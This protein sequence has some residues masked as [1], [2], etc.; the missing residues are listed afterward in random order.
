MPDLV[1]LDVL[2]EPGSEVG[3]GQRATL[4]VTPHGTV[5]VEVPAAITAEAVRAVR[6]LGPVRA[7]IPSHPHMFGLQSVW[8]EALGD[9]DV[10]VARADEHWLG[11]RPRRLRIWSG[12]RE[13]LP[14]VRATQPGGHFPGSAVVHW[15]G[16]DGAGVLLAGDTIAANPDRRTVAFMRSYPNRIPLSAAVVERIA[17]HVAAPP[18][19]RLYDNFGG[20]IPAG[21][22]EAVAASA[23]R[24][25]AW[26][27]GD[28]D[29]LTGGSGDEGAAGGAAS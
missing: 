6:T 3:I 5:M 27:R 21:A 29:H 18:F 26:V 22:S 24:H 16:A 25:A 13:I 19:A 1:G 11:R 17:A 14:G 10:W 28:F 9:A 4:I 15:S 23:R 8:S 12:T 2:P 20:T 7:I